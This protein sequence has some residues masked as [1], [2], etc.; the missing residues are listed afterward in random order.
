MMDDRSNDTVL[1]LL[2]L[3]GDRLE[4]F[5]EGD[6]TALETLGESIEQ[7]NLSADELQAA[8]LVLRSLGGSAS[9][10]AQV[11][12]ESSPGKHAQRV[13]SAEERA[14]LSPEAW[15]YLLELRS[16]GSLDAGQ[17]ERVLDL[18]TGCGVRP[19]GVELA[20]EIA[21]RVALKFDE[22]DLA[23]EPRHGDFDLAH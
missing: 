14:S 4:S 20:R 8:I 10:S 13:L 18:L 21:T 6:E 22:K 3:L 23:G 12:V 5:L 2:R 15:G 16:R 19:V 11:A 17:F 1:R 7:E 9:I